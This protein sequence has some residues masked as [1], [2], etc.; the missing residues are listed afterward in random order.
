MKELTLFTMRGCPH[1]RMAREYMRELCQEDP[2]QLRLLLCALLFYGG[3]KAARGRLYQR[4][5]PQGAGHRAERLTRG[6]TDAAP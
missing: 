2:R 4:K 1:C 6:G 5:D 3:Q